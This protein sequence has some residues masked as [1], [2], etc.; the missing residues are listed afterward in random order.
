[1][2]A[3]TSAN[4]PLPDARAVR[5]SPLGKAST[6]HAGLGHASHMRRRAQWLGLAN[7]SDATR[8]EA[9]LSVSL[10]QWN[11]V[12]SKRQGRR[13]VLLRRFEEEGQLALTD[14]RCRANPGNRRRSHETVMNRRDG[15]S[16]ASDH[17]AI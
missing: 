9:S 5:P 12:D 8:A 6:Q 11:G 1:M 15:E 17:D 16:V 10:S 7:T 4:R 14:P 2:S 3:D 13:S